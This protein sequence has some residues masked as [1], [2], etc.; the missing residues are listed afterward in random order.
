M[1]ASS[2]YRATRSDNV[3]D[4][5]LV[6]RVWGDGAETTTV[7]DGD[8]FWFAGT[9]NYITGNVAADITGGGP[10]AYGFAFSPVS[11][12]SNAPLGTVAEPAYQGAETWVAG[13]YT[14]VNS[15][16]Q[17][18]LE[19]SGNKVYGSYAGLTVWYLG[20]DGTFKPIGTAGTVK[21]FTIW[22][23]VSYGIYLYY[24]NDLTINGYVARG[25]GPAVTSSDW[26]SYGLY[27]QPTTGSRAWSSPTPISRDSISASTPRSEGSATP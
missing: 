19:F 1:P 15:N 5:N 20:M 13:Q 26:A 21:D 7:R 12:S 14:L 23:I 9:N 24:T 11:G 2:P 4:Q 3:I 27:Q 6:V 17:P 8:G 16:S 22:N 10:Y 25:G 18:L